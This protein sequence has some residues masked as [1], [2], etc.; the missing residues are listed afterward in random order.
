MKIAFIE[1]SP[2]TNLYFFLGNMPLLGNLYLGTML[3]EKGHEVK[4]F[5]ETNTRMYN[6]K[7]GELH[8]YL[9][10]ADVVGLTSVTH[11]IN[12]AYEIADAVKTQYPDK[13]VLFGGSH[14]SACPEEA[15]RHCDNVVVGEAE[16]VIFDV[17]EGN[18][19]PGIIQG[20]RTDINAIPP[21]DMSLMQD[22]KRNY[23]NR[24]RDIAPIMASRGCPHNCIFCSVTKMFGRKYRI[25][26]ADLVMEEVRMRY[27]EGHRFA[28][29]YDDNFAANP[30]KTKIFLEKLIREDIDFH[31]SSQ[32]SIHAA[33]DKELLD[34]LR[35]SKCRRLFIGVESVNPEALKDYHKDQTVEMIETNIR[36]I[37]EAGLMVHSMFIFGA[38][39]DTEAS[40][41]QTMEFAKTS[42]SD[43]AQFSVLY[44]IPGTELYDNMKGENRL[45]V[46]DWTY[47]DGSHSVIIPKNVTPLRLQ[48]MS[49]KAYRSFYKDPLSWLATHLGFFVWKILSRKYMKHLRMVSRQMKRENITFRRLQ[50]FWEFSNLKWL[51]HLSQK[52]G[53][54]DWDRQLELFMQQNKDPA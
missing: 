19:K 20:S 12:R 33:R 13:K 11:T 31:W 4:V 18:P 54:K 27:N 29:F 7:T 43:S 39:S 53:F 25:R 21:I 52:L 2:K 24:Y 23:R 26:D 42:K 47:Y 3:K 34:L 46:Q 48:Q 41:R 44:P 45:H 38:D 5:K 51:R 50:K 8:P 49:I 22:R 16:N 40:M 10:E 1:P 37:K 28:F 17:I 9:K 15:L 36:K 32:F 6:K 30:K 14:A 35:R